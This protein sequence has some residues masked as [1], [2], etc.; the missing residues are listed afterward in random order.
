M[1]INTIEKLVC[2]TYNVSLEEIN[3]RCRENRIVFPR[4]LIMYL[5]MSWLS[6]TSHKAGDLFNRDHSTALHAKKTVLS[7]YDTEV[8]HRINIDNI[9]KKMLKELLV[10]DFVIRDIN[11]SKLSENYTKSLL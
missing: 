9:E 6:L 7:M 5:S 8:I 2:D 4:Q 11:L 10:P 1:N 3:T